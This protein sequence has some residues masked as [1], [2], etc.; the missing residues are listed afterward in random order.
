MKSNFRD[1]S[2][3]DSTNASETNEEKSSDNEFNEMVKEA[4]QK[5]KGKEKK[6]STPKKSLS[7]DLLDFR[8]QQLEYQEEQDKVFQNMLHETFEEQQ[9]ADIEERKKDREFFLELAK[10]FSGE[11]N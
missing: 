11:N 10:I 8:K 7:E 3:L 1:L 5:L 2:S 6:K 4:E 9:K